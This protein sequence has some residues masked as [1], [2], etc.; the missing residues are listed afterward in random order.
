MSCL[1]GGFSQ[2]GALALYTAL[3]MEKPLA[4]IL[5]LSSWLPLH[6]T[7]PEVEWCRVILDHGSVHLSGLGNAWESVSNIWWNVFFFPM[8][9]CWTWLISSLTVCST[10]SLSY[11]LLNWS[12]GSMLGA[13]QEP[14]CQSLTDNWPTISWGSS[15]S[16]LPKK[17]MNHIYFLALLKSNIVLCC[18]S[19]VSKFLFEMFCNIFVI[20]YLKIE[21]MSWVS[22]C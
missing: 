17:N 21:I 11:V 12:V 19:Y 7:F 18:T 15:V 2:G 20:S 9:C 8:G 1:P 14:V 16:K 3:T 6:K 22:L 10:L 4:G 13:C 5:A